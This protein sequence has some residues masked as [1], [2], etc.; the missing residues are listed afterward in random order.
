MGR[1][2]GYIPTGLTLIREY[3]F[4]ITISV[5]VPLIPCGNYSLLDIKDAGTYKFRKGFTL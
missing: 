1:K 4:T 3:T 2:V 5:G